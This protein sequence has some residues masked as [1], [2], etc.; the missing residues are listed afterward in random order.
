MASLL[1]V[2]GGE[3]G[4]HKGLILSMWT[5]S[6][7][8]EL[9]NLFLIALLIALTAFFV[10][11]E[12]A[13]VKVRGSRIDQLI[14]EGNKK[15]LSAKN[16]TSHLDEYLSACQLGITITALGLGWLGEPTFENLLH[17]L[18]ERLSLNDS[19]AQILSFGFAFAIVTF[20]HV[21][22]GELSPK[23]FA[24]QKAEEI[25]LAISKPLIMFYK[26]L[27]PFIWLLNSSARLLTGLFGLKPASEQE[28]AHSEEEL[29]IILSE[30][31]EQGEI[32][33]SEYS[34]VENIFEFDNRLA[35]EIMVPRTEI[36]ALDK[37][38]I[39]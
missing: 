33:Q 29:R 35:K 21:V 28:L 15:A 12:F 23:T 25:A 36:I 6:G 26:I 30:S 9:T 13:I 31:Y 20:L 37:E 10:A 11:S 17:P 32:N 24:I 39:P 7:S 8:L 14:A 22:I 34:Y 5:S 38:L 27:F 19:I 16:V 3:K 2:L 1:F 4:T 18:F